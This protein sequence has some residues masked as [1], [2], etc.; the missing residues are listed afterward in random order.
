MDSGVTESGTAPGSGPDTESG[1]GTFVGPVDAQ[2]ESE[3]ARAGVSDWKSYESQLNA[4]A[5]LKYN[6][7]QDQQQLFT[8]NLGWKVDHYCSHVTDEPP[9]PPLDCGPFARAKEIL[10]TYRFPPPAIIKGIFQP[11]LQLEGRNMLLKARFL[12]FTF[13]FGTRIN[14][15]ID[16]TRNHPT[17][18]PVQVW[19]YS[20]RTLRGHFEMG[21]IS[22]EVLKFL[23]M[24]TIEFNISAY[25]KPDRIPN[26][27]YRL[28]FRIF[29]RLLQKYFAYSSMRRMRNMVKHGGN[30][31]KVVR[32]LIMF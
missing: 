13:F 21:E 14:R 10:R 25:S 19:G 20:Y 31:P 7:E 23:E 17:R 4:L 2:A 28:G 30:P 12:G 26:F 32:P 6:F 16:E 9:G 1:S 22:F 8:E 27:F 3:S 11:D 15:V 29:G 24:G 18:G 5:E